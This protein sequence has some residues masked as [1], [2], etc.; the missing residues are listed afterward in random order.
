MTTHFTRP[1]R[2]GRD[3]EEGTESLR[4]MLNDES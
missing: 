1:H 3:E 4:Q 2:F